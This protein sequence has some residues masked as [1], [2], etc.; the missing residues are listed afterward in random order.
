MGGG[1]GGGG[2]GVG[3]GGGGLST[4][5]QFSSTRPTHT[6]V[7]GHGFLIS[8]EFIWICLD[9]A[10]FA[11]RLFRIYLDIAHFCIRAIPKFAGLSR[12]WPIFDFPTFSGF[13]RLPTIPANVHLANPSG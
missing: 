11:S 7:C 4:T 9:V 8:Q 5:M 13:V 1:G 6:S 12:I 10:S 2:G 3:G